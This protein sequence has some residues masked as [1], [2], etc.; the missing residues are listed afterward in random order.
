MEKTQ[1][2][3]RSRPPNKKIKKKRQ[4]LKPTAQK[5]PS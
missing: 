2:K 4:K 1:L 3:N 5:N